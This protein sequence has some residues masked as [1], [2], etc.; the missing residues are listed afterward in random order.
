MGWKDADLIPIASTDGRSIVTQ[1]SDFG[2]IVF[3]Q[4]VDFVGIIYLRPGHFPANK[5]IVTLKAILSE[6]PDLT[7]PFI[8]TAF[9][10]G[11]AVKIRVR[12]SIY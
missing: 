6:D 12:N 10:N 7:S 8:V 5:H 4:T 1:D 9:N 11:D 2:S 3:T